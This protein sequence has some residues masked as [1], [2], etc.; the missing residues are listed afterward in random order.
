[1]LGYKNKVKWLMPALML[2]FSL[3]ISSCPAPT[4]QSGLSPLKAVSFQLDALRKE[5]LLSFDE[6]IVGFNADKITPYKDDKALDSETYN[7]NIQDGKILIRLDTLT[8]GAVYTVSLEEGAVTGLNGSTNSKLEQKNSPKAVTPSILVSSISVSTAAKTISLEFTTSV[9]L[10]K[11]G[12]IEVYKGSEKLLDEKFTISGLPSQTLVITLTDPMGDVYSIKIPEGTLKDTLENLNSV[13]E[14]GSIDTSTPALKSGGDSLNLDILTNKLTVNFNRDIASF[15]NTKIQVYKTPSG[16]T[17]ALDSTE[18]TLE[19]STDNMALD[20]KFTDFFSDNDQYRVKLLVGA[21]TAPYGIESTAEEHTES[22]TVTVAPK[23]RPWDLSLKGS[24]FTATFD[25]ELSSLDTSI[26]TVYKT[27]SG[28]TTETVLTNPGDYTI[29]IRDGEK[30][31]VDITLTT[32][33]VLG[34]KIKAGFKISAVKDTNGFGNLF[35]ETNEYT[36]RNIWVQVLENDT[37][38]KTRWSSRDYHT[39]VVFDNKIWVLGGNDGN[40]NKDDVWYS[41]N[42]KDWTNAN[43]TSHW[44]GRKQHTSVVFDNKIWVLG[45]TDGKTK[46]NDIWSST[47]GKDWT[48]V[49]AT[50]HWSA[51]IG[52][53]SVVF[54][55]KI[56]V[57][58]G[59]S[60]KYVN[61]IWYSTNGKDWTEVNATNHWSGRWGHSSVVFDNKI[62]VLRGFPY[63]FRNDIWSSTNGKDWI[64]VNATKELPAQS[65]HNSVVFDNKIW[66][67]GGN[68]GYDGKIKN[69]IWYSANGKDWV[70]TKDTDHWSARMGHSSVVFDNKIW[71]LGGGDSSGNNDVWYYG[72]P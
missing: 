22:E 40:T 64:S 52:H 18:K 14:S 31:K 3:I 54:D 23:L 32:P 12:S 17:E 62:W 8:A 59:D 37:S 13:I 72:L 33:P 11:E 53:S 60:S 25:R 42:G 29:A 41:T 65:S 16:G 50:K 35:Q 28:S 45:G 67:F 24:V 47:N 1:M 43:A 68:G 51:R 46:N 38:T 44:S 7:L 30:S 55:N 66:M 63:G 57:L 9:S 20:I 5:L 61:D 34:D 71:V 56:W 15:D 48:K 27:A 10:N 49:D 4:G 19:I 70:D 21:L 39:S 36:V 69:D 6:T 2:I 58:G 26:I